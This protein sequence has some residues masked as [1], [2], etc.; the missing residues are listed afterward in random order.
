MKKERPKIC[1]DYE[2]VNK[3]REH[4]RIYRDF[5]IAVAERLRMKPSE[6]LLRE[7]DDLDEKLWRELW[8]LLKGSS[9]DENEG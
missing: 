5:I 9:G 8:K 2:D 4:L 6:D 3:L 7:I 1:I